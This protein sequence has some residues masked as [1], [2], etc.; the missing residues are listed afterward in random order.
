LRQTPPAGAGWV[1]ELKL[2]GYRIH[3]RID[4]ASVK[5]LT[6]TGLDWADRYSFT[7]AELAKLRCRRAYIDGELCALDDKGL[8][9]FA[10][11][12]AA[13]DSRASQ[14]LV[15]FAFDLLHLDGEDLR[16]SPLLERKARLADLLAEPPAGLR[17]SQH[18][19]EPGPDV[20]K[21]VCGLGCESAP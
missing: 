9:S 1:H 6:R 7:V 11:M 18:F 21:A 8:S 10:A 20:L 12:Q 3:A 13:S 4:G 17:Y 19:A 16:Q 14:G 15:Y 5:L 2:D